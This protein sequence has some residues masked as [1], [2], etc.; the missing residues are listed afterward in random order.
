VVTSQL[1][2]TSVTNPEGEAVP[3]IVE[4]SEGVWVGRVR[5]SSSLIPVNSYVMQF[6]DYAALGEMLMQ[7]AEA[8]A[9]THTNK[10]SF[11]LDYEYKLDPTGV[12]IK[13]IREV[14]VSPQSAALPICFGEETQ[15]RTFESGIVESDFGTLSRPF[16]AH[17]GKSTWVIRT[18]PFEMTPEMLAGPVYT[19]ITVNVHEDGTIRHFEGALNSLPGYKHTFTND[20]LID[21]WSFAPGGATYQLKTTLVS[22]NVTGIR[23]VQTVRDW[24][25]ELAVTY[26][27]EKTCIWFDNSRLPFTNQVYRT[28]VFVTRL[29]PL[30]STNNTTLPIFRTWTK[31]NE[32][33]IRSDY[34]WLRMPDS[35]FGGG[36]YTS[37]L[38]DWNGSQIEGMTEEP[39]WLGGFFSQTYASKR[40]NIAESFVFDP[41]LEPEI[42]ASVLQE[43]KAANIRMIY[44][45]DVL[46]LVGFDGEVRFEESVRDG[47][48][49]FPNY[50]DH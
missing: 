33:K 2:A 20:T 4:A 41:W 42:P 11:L 1:G 38:V 7:T 18:G 17:Y 21:E 14:P 44:C 39:I 3:E 28:N 13:Q 35:A 26:P 40:K 23:Q 34:Y 32:W 16:T 25:L 36:G 49:G 37:P 12:V 6:T 15:F 9:A 46:G 47:K 30:L 29:Q 22:T 19:N 43:L 24:N 10:T 48:P 27:N 45:S 31:T 50:F 5:Q 8:Y